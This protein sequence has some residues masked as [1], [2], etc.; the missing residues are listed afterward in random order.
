MAAVSSKIP[1]PH[2]VASRIAMFKLIKN[3]EPSNA[4]AVPEASIIH[5]ANE[6][7]K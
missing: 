5:S 4:P 2:E 6:S 1:T 7:G 3:R